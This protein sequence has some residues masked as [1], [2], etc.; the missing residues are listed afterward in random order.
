[1]RR[2]LDIELNPRSVSETVEPA[3][4]RLSVEK[5]AWAK[6]AQELVKALVTKAEITGVDMAQPS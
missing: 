3:D 1:L 6:A 4:A 5:I 2:Y